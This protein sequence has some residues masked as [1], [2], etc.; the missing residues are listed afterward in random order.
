MELMKQ[1]RRIPLNLIVPGDNDREL[2]REDR[3]EELADSIKA[4]GLLQPIT[5]R[6]VGDVFRIVAGERR[7]RA[8]RDILGLSEIEALVE[9]VGDGEE[10][11]LMLVENL[12][13]HDLAIS[14]EAE[15]FLGR[16]VSTAEASHAIATAEHIRR[17]SM[18]LEQV[19]KGNAILLPQGSRNSPILLYNDEVWIHGKTVR[20]IYEAQ[21]EGRS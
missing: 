18:T 12:C 2:F 3:L 5:L 4:N 6:P 7:F 16:Q 1:L 13:R 20:D 10:S 15:T 14:E 19:L 17:S 9:E 21:L 8:C 11:M